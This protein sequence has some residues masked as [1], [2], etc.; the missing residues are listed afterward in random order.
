MTE[1]DPVL[2]RLGELPPSEPD[3]AF[4]TNLRE[5]A[6]RVLRPRRVHPVWTLAA[7]ASVIVYLGWA[8][9]FTSG[10]Y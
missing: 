1:K 2:Q 8:V 7:A 3:A 10:L 4:S 9:Y 5:R 6:H